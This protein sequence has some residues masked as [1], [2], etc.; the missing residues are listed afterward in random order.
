MPP[1]DRHPLI[2]WIRVLE[3]G[4][5]PWVPAADWDFKIDQLRSAALVLLPHPRT[6]DLIGLPRDPRVPALLAVLAL[7]PGSAGPWLAGHGALALERLLAHTRAC[8]DDSLVAEILGRVS[9]HRCG[10]SPS[11]SRPGA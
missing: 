3:A 8:P 6:L 1:P 4:P 11:S 10:Q 9:V 5:P 2:G 7:P